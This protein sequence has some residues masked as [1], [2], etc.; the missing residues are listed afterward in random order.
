MKC[1][2]NS[3]PQAIVYSMCPQSLWMVYAHL[4]PVTREGTLA[5]NGT[6]VVFYSV[7]RPFVLHMLLP[8]RV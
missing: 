6:W 5:F 4:V 1:R 3:L 8:C 7:E 2:S